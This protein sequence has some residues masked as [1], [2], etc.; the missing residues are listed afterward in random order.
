MTLSEYFEVVSQQ[1][2]DLGFRPEELVL[3]A[4]DICQYPQEEDIDIRVCGNR[5]VIY[6]AE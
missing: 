4:V 1:V 6:S 5:V 2:I 3:E